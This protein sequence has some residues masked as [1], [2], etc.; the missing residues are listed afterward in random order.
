[1]NA[2]GGNDSGPSRGEGGRRGLDRVE[3]KAGNSG[4]DRVGKVGQGRSGRVGKKAL[5]SRH[6]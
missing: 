6:S 1:M 2:K 5:M 3:K 4:C